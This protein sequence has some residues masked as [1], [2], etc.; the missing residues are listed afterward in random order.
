MKHILFFF[1]KLRWLI[2]GYSKK[3]KCSGKKIPLRTQDLVG[4]SWSWGSGGTR[5]SFYLYSHTS[6]TTV[7][8]ATLSGQSTAPHQEQES[9]CVKES[10]ELHFLSC[11]AHGYWDS[12]FCPYQ[13]YLLPIVTTASKSTVVETEIQWASVSPHWLAGVG[14]TRCGG[15]P[16]TDKK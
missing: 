3:K 12:I 15:V 9:L 5:Q 8:Q 13:C 4:C 6:A 10:F 1:P 7:S 14:C 16:G 11:I 2:L